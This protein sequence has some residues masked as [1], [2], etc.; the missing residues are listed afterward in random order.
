[1]KSIASVKAWTKAALIAGSIA[2][3]AG[4]S[5]DGTVYETGARAPY[6]AG[7]P[8]E[9]AG[10]E[11]APAPAPAPATVATGNCA[12][13]RPAVPPGH[14]MTGLAFPSGDVRSSAVLVQQVMPQTVRL[15]QPYTYEIHVT[16]ITN[17]T[18]Q[19][20]VVNLENVDNQAVQSSVPPGSPSPGG[21]TSWLLGDMASCKTQVIKVTAKASKQGTSSN[22]LSV[23]Y[24]NVLCAAANV[25][26]PALAIK[27]TMTAEA[28]LC[29]T[30]TMTFEVRNTGSGSAEN[31]VIKDTLPAGL[32]TT[33]G[34]TSV[35]IPVGTLAAGQSATRTLTAKASKTGRYE[36]NATASAAGGLTADSGKVAVVV[37]QPVLAIDAECGGN[38]L[39]N[40]NTV[41]KFTVKNSG[42]A[43]SNN[44][45]ITAPVPANTTFVSADSGGRLEGTNVVWDAGSIAPNTSKTV[46]MTVRTVGMGQVTCSATASG[47]CA[48][49]VSDSCNSS[50]IGVPDIGTLV[51][52]DDGVVQVGDPH[53]YRVEVQNQG[54]VNLTNVKMVVTLPAGMEFVSSVDGKLVGGKV[55]FSFGTLPAGQRKA[56]SFVVRSSKSGELLVIGETTCSEL[57]TPIR[58]DELTN[59]IDR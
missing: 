51:T 54:Q 55:E 36:N 45:R 17:G 22:C 6:N 20:V 24:N 37:K 1:M 58:D 9:T 26:E 56:S 44:T 27:K 52:D 33:D 19:N 5:S 28:L 50:V 29:D 31:V 53:T 7:G 32:T 12:N 8:I 15:N 11:P 13:Y 39:M 46:S 2:A 21:G 47:V 40:R 35:E 3:L 42:D 30:I 57:K 49:A 18:L 14:G 4:C 25:V 43:A 38:T 10:K 41:C 48:N 59:F 34:K 16:N 23:S